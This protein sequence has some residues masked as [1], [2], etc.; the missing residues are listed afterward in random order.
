MNPV[1]VNAA[2]RDYRMPAQQVPDTVIEV[3]RNL[4][5]LQRQKNIPAANYL[6]V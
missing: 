4:V 3:L 6:H 2:L 1:N 5:R